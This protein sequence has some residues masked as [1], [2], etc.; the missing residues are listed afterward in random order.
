[1][2]WKLR[3]QGSP[4]TIDN[5]TPQKIVEGLQ[6]GLWEGTDEVMGPNDK[7][8]VTIESHPLFEDIAYEI[9]EAQKEPY[10]ED[11]EEQRIDMNPL[12]DVCLVLLVF[13][14]LATTM[15]VLEKVINVPQS[16]SEQPGEVTEVRLEDVINFTIMVKVYP[17][18]G[19]QPVYEVEG[20]PVPESELQNRF[21][22]FVKDSRKTEMIIE[23]RG[24]SWGTVVKVIDAAGGARIKKIHFAASRGGASA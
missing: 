24:V 18:E 22:Q 13:F 17:G 20:R 14:I 23:A 5:L 15:Q 10:I 8:W 11:P 16:Q 19:G 7:K 21:E 2:S 4:K 3:H 1:M 12:I 6:D 9:E